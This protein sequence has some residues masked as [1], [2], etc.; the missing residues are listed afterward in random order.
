M[1]RLGS[2]IIR[3]TYEVCSEEEYC[4]LICVVMTF[5]VLSEYCWI[6]TKC[7]IESHLENFL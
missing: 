5:S 1:T 3:N 6:E 4:T 7:L 2:C